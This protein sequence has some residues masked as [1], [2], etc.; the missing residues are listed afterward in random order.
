MS[1]QS[2]GMPNSNYSGTFHK[3]IQGSDSDYKQFGFFL[4]CGP[5]SNSHY[6]KDGPRKVSKASPQRTE[7]LKKKHETKDA[8][9]LQLVIISGLDFFL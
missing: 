5:Y 1:D 2:N 8:H 7:I 6:R 9:A 4:Q 3:A